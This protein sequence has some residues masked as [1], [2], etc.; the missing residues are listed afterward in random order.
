MPIFEVQSV[1]MSKKRHIRTSWVIHIFAILHAVVAL[2]CRLAGVED[3]LLLTVLTMSMALIICIRKCLSVEFSAA[4]IIV[5]NIIGYYMGTFGAQVIQR[6][7]ESPFAVHAISTAITTEILGW[8]ILALT[9]IFRQKGVKRQS[10]EESAYLPWLILAMIGIFIFRLTIIFVVSYDNFL[11]GDIYDTSAKVFSDSLSLTTLICIN[12][13]YIRYVKKLSNKLSKTGKIVMLIAFMLAASLVETVLV[14]DG[15]SLKANPDF[16]KEFPIIF[17]TSL[18][19]QITVYC[20]VY[21]VNY[22]FTARNEMHEEREKANMAQY[23]YVKLKHQVN[24]HFLFNSLN[25]LDCLICEEKT[26]RASSYTHKLAGIY[27]YMLKSEDEIV[28]PLRDELV[29]VG[30]YV[31]LLKERFPVGFHVEINVPE[32]LYHKCILPCSIQLLIENAT[33]HNAVSEDTP[34]TIKVEVENGSIKV[35]NNLIP[36]VTKSPS[37][38]LGLKYIKQMYLDLSGKTIGI[39]KTDTEYSVT[40]PLI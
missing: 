14:S 37:T 36:K 26:E 30:L 35:M 15:L 1:Y 19:A 39:E 29:F 22:A 3:E 23:R 40:L 10:V 34:L 33:K 4:S 9:K 5:V 32:E 13:L 16:W 2:C 12:I 8:S 31:D 6:L 27:R 11:N 20:V 24:P 17:I 7:I 38:G 21:M 18:L 28:V 25:I